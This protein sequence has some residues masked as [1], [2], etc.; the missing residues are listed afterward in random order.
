M[1]SSNIKQND[2][3]ILCVFMTDNDFIEI[4]IDPSQA[5]EDELFPASVFQTDQKETAKEPIPTPDE[6]NTVEN[7]QRIETDDD[8]QTHVE[9]TPKHEIHNEFVGMSQVLLLFFIIYNLT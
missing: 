1:C 4:T 3:L 2:N 8:E 7:V 6:T 5:K 9:D